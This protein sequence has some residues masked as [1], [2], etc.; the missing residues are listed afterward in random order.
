MAICSIVHGRTC[1]DLRFSLSMF[2]YQRFSL[3]KQH[4]PTG[5]IR[6]FPIRT[7]IGTCEVIVL[8]TS[9]EII[10]TAS[11][12]HDAGANIFRHGVI[13]AGKSPKSPWKLRV[14]Y[15]LYSWENHH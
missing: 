1:G 5:F 11:L 10:H 8:A 13:M 15:S 3:Q 4:V 12:V 14:I 7:S 9:I 2:V 6:G